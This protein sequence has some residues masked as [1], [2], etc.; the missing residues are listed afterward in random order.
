MKDTIP[1]ELRLISLLKL[2]SFHSLNEQV[3]V[4]QVVAHLAVMQKDPDSNLS[5][6]EIINISK[7]FNEE[8]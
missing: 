6:A 7:P 2:L 1:T 5:K 8:M 4:A 3:T